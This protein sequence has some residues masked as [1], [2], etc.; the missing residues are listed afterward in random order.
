MPISSLQYLETLET[1]AIL[2]SFLVADRYKSAMRNPFNPGSGVPP[3]YLAGRENHL[4]TFER[5]LESIDDGH[6]ENMIVHRLEG[7]GR[8]CS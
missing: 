3:P 8:R 2:I 7:P 6:I 5:A 4:K 1:G